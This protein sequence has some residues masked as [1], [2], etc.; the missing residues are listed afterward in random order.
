MNSGSGDVHPMRI[1]IGHWD[2]LLGEAQ[3]KKENP[4]GLRDAIKC[5]NTYLGGN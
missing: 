2:H 3:T 4:R 5:P 1:V